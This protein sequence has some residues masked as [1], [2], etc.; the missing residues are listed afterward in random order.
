MALDKSNTHYCRRARRSNVMN[1]ERW[2]PVKGYEGRYEVSSLGR[3]KSLSREVRGSRLIRIAPECIMKLHYVFSHRATTN[4]YLVVW[5]RDGK[6]HIK[7]FVHRLVAQA[8]IENPQC[9]PVANHKNGNKMDARVENLEW[10]TQSEN[11]RHYHQTLKPA[12]VVPVVETPISA[13]DLPF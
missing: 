1:L 11:I 6:R 12:R 10:V 5:L 13:T 3:I 4:P 9:L 7:F 2:L 8:F